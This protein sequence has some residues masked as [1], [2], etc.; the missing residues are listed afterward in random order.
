MVAGGLNPW[1]GR[2]R[3]GSGRLRCRPQ[4]ERPALRHQQPED[5]G[6]VGPGELGAAGPE[7]LVVEQGVAQA[8]VQQIPARVIEPLVQLLKHG[9]CDMVAEKRGLS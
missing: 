5:L 3:L 9:W 6:R 7:V 4:G 1:R 8:E 2:R